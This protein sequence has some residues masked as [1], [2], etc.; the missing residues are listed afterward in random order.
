[1]SYSSIHT[2][3]A[4]RRHD[5][6]FD[7]PIEDIAVAG[8]LPDERLEAVVEEL[9]ARIRML[10]EARERYRVW[11][12]RTTVL[13]LQFSQDVVEKCRR[14][15]AEAGRG[16]FHG[17]WTSDPLLHAY[18]RICSSPLELTPLALGNVLYSMVNAVSSTATAEDPHSKLQYAYTLRGNV[19]KGSDIRSITTDMMNS[20]EVF[21]DADDKLFQD[22]L[23][24]VSGG[25][26]EDCHMKQ[27]EEVYRYLQLIN[28]RRLAPLL[29]ELPREGSGAMDVDKE[30][31]ETELLSFSRLPYNEMVRALRLLS[32]SSLA[33]GN[34]PQAAEDDENMLNRRFFRH[35]SEGTFSQL[36][37]VFSLTDLRIIT[38]YLDIT[39]D[40][41][42]A[43][44]QP[45]FSRRMASHFVSGND[46]LQ[47]TLSFSEYLKLLKQ[48]GSPSSLYFGL[49]ITM[50]GRGYLNLLLPLSLHQMPTTT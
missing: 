21:M 18:N 4:D 6:T 10:S 3:L 33:A 40:L 23:A 38:K 11:K 8:E 30:T 19:V 41:L 50:S 22:Y 15:V 16:D 28:L 24:A 13:T 1:M 9:K 5:P 36:M 48:V 44:H 43:M 12:G 14:A 47:K 35:L 42:V 34:G 29:R 20:S 39:G 2:Y 46:Q 32:L 27:A 37:R 25:R 31:K 49:Y 45:N 7:I 17:T 26:L